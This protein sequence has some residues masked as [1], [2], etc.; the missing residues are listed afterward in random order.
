[1]ARTSLAGLDF[2]M[3]DLETKATRQLTTFSSL[4][5]LRTFDIAPDGKSIV[6]DRARSNADVIVIDLPKPGAAAPGPA[7]R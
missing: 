6:F 5:L 1:M 7:S 4:G 3:V 2:R